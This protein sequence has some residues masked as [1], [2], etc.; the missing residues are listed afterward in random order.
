MKPELVQFLRCR[1][2]GKSDFEL[3]SAERDE[4]EIR[5]GTLTCASCT[6]SCEI[7]NGVVDM[8]A[9][10]ASLGWETCQ[11]ETVADATDQWLLDTE[12]SY[13]S[14]NISHA[15]HF[16][17]GMLLNF[18]KAVDEM[19]LSEAGN[20]TQLLDL[21]AGTTWLTDLLAQRGA[22]CV[23]L[24]MAAAKYVGLESADVFMKKHLTYYERVLG[25][26]NK[27]PFR[28]NSFDIVLSHSAIH[29]SPNI[30]DALS[31]VRAVLRPGGSLFL[32]NEPTLSLSGL[33]DAPITGEEQVRGENP[34]SLFGYLLALRRAGFSSIR[35]YFPPGLSHRLDTLAETNRLGDPR[36][37][38]Q[39]VKYFFIGR[40]LP[41]WN[42]SPV[43]RY[44]IRRYLFWPYAFVVGQ[45]VIIKAS[46]SARQAA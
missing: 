38:G 9:E 42:R 30:R 23:A 36:G 18:D 39:K 35:M 34:T 11:A 43:F 8:R 6:Q 10:T 25:D 7:R 26:M 16:S 12:V 32:V 20:R 41:L 40:I 15:R 1:T 17:Y 29:H 19:H 2:C 14:A 24:D 46:K 33:F 27:L 31:Q 28:D 3:R 37:K 22:S 45:F 21:A 44:I 13:R 5:F 4:R